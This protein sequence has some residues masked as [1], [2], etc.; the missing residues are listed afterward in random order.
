VLSFPCLSPMRNASA[1]G[2]VKKH[3]LRITITPKSKTFSV[4]LKILK[5]LIQ[6][7]ELG[8]KITWKS[9]GEK[10]RSIASLPGKKVRYH[11]KNP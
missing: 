6:N 1:K 9:V 7:Q 10:T 5:I 2:R 3:N 8:V 4:I 11:P